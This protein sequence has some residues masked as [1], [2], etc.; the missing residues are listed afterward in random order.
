MKQRRLVIVESTLVDRCV[1]LLNRRFPDAN[2]TT[3]GCLSIL[4]DQ[5]MRLFVESAE[6]ELPFDLERQEKR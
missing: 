2:R 6:P 5:A 1:A 4:L 3:E